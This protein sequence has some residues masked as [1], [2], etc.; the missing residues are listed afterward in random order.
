VPYGKF[1]NPQILADTIANEIE[2]TKNHRRILYNISDF[3]S[4]LRSFQLLAYK[5]IIHGK[6]N[7]ATRTKVFFIKHRDVP[8]QRFNKRLTFALSQARART[9]TFGIKV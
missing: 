3:L 6:I 8:V 9:G 7:A 1:L 4:K 2:R 5:I